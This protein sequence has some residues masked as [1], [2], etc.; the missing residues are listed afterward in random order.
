MKRTSMLLVISLAGNLVAITATN[1][2]AAAAAPHGHPRN[3]RHRF[4]PPDPCLTAHARTAAGRCGAIRR[5]V[6]PGHLNPQP[7]PPG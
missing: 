6:A 3:V 2:A 5:S 1:P 4:E 7:L